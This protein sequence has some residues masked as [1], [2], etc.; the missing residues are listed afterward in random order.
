MSIQ[1]VSAEQ[2]VELFHH[3]HHVLGQDPDAK[4]ARTLEDWRDLP[5]S[6][7]R[8]MIAAFRLALVELGATEAEKKEARRYY[9]KPGEAEWGC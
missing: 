5:E 7:K 1:E 2:F 9:A 8:R 3:Y 6:E 4:G